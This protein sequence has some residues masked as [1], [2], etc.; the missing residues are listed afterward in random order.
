MRFL[1][2]GGY[3]MVLAPWTGPQRLGY[4]ASGP[5]TAH[6]ADGLVQ[7]H[8]QKDQGAADVYDALTSKRV[9][10]PPFTHEKACAMIRDAS[11]S[12]FD[13]DLVAA[14]IALQDQFA[15]SREQYSALEHDAA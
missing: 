10:K 15:K 13:P 5:S 14:F 4:G 2:T 1:G 7:D 6:L 3:D 8:G 12:Q 11:G 9:Y